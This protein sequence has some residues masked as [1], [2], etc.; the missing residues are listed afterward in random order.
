[1]QPFCL[2][3][4]AWPSVGTSRFSSYIWLVHLHRLLLKC[5]QTIAER[6]RL[7][8]EAEEEKE[9]EKERKEI[10]AVSVNSSVPA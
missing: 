6:E 8:K 9:R 4:A 2:C 5:L 10:R 7:Y 1:M 3:P